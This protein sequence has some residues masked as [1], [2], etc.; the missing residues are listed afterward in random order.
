MTRHEIITPVPGVFYRRADPNSAP[1]K[2]DGDDVREG[3][4]IAV[5]EIMKN[6]QAIE[7]DAS[8]R[9]VEWLVDNEDAVNVGQPVA[10][11][12]VDI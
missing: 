7:S 10:V 5:V 2:N 1:F 12:E 11:L 6:F 9:L 3:E 8:G 4:T